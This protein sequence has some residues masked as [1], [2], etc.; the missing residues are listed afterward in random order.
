MIMV[1]IC[2]ENITGFKVACLI[3]SQ[4]LYIC[5]VFVIVLV[6]LFVIW[7]NLLLKLTNFFFKLC[8]MYTYFGST[9]I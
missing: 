9:K 8:N 3:L 7:P 1:L 4:E 5:Y 2:M 6:L